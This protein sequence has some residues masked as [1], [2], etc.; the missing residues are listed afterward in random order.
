MKTL[1]S[2]KYFPRVDPVSLRPLADLRLARNTHR[3]NQGQ[4]C[5]Q[6]VIKMGFRPSTGVFLNGST[7]RIFAVQI[8]IRYF[9]EIVAPITPDQA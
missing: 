7:F 9:Q 8:D 1:P 3:L 5:R 6:A 4:R 2:L